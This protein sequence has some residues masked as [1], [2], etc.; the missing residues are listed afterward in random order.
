MDYPVGPG[1]AVDHFSYEIDFTGAPKT[2]GR[3]KQLEA[4]LAN[5][6]KARRAI[7]RVVGIGDL[8]L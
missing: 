7:D 8:N 3:G 6:C 5:F 4:A 2:V 1:V